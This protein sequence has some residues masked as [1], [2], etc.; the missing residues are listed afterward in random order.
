MEGIDNIIYMLDEML[1]TPRKRHITGGILLSISALFG[2]LAITV[3]AICG[4]GATYIALKKKYEDL[5]QEEIESVKEVYKKKQDV[6]EEVSNQVD[7]NTAESII[8]QSG[9]SPI[10]Y[11]E[12]KSIQVISPDEFGDNLDYDKIE[13][14]YYTDGFL[15]DD[16]N[17]IINDIRKIVDDALDHFGDYEED[18]VMVVN[19]DLQVYYEIVRDPRRYV[20]VIAKTP[21]KVEV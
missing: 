12:T 10:R 18:V 17:N 6:Q 4:C 11:N 21:Y 13:L 20:D 2:G 15:A 9:Y 19:H 8:K 14:T 16:D 1:D 3:M 5:A 7:A